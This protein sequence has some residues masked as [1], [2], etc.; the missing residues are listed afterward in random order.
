MFE[1]DL[2]SLASG[3]AGLTLV[4][5]LTIPSTFAIAAQFRET[6]PRSSTYE[7]KDGVATPES[8]AA[9][10]TK[11]PKIVLSIFTILG[12][13]VSIALAILGTLHLTSDDLFFESWFNVAGWVMYHVICW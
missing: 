2:I 5:L 13:L 8:I 1:S 9:F 6:K 7:D 11:V 12:L 10:T 3:A 4:L